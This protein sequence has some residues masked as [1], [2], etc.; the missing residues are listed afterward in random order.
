MVYIDNIVYLKSI[1]EH[2]QHLHQIFACLHKA[3]LT[4]NQKKCN[5]VLRHIV[6]EKGV[7][8]DPTKVAA[9]KSFPV[10]QTVK[11]AQRFF[12]FA[13]WHH[14]FIHGFQRKLLPCTP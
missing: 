1:S 5:Q 9:V 2:L 14:R 10:P 6:S 3:G 8:T 4:L 12:K 13:G 11:E 7:T